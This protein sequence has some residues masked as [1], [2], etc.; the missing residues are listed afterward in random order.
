MRKACHSSARPRPRPQ[1]SAW[2]RSSV[3]GRVVNRLLAFERAHQF[4]LA[5][6]GPSAV[7]RRRLLDSSLVLTSGAKGFSKPTRW[8]DLSSLLLLGR[9]PE[10]PIQQLVESQ[11]RASASSAVFGPSFNHLHTLLA[12][13]ESGAGS[14]ILPDFVTAAA[15]R[16]Q[17]T[18]QLLRGTVS[19]TFTRS[20]GPDG[21]TMMS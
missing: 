7:R 19:V 15:S 1:R 18:I 10:I 4:D 3:V 14:A 20:P 11:V 2:L 16:Y 9:P 21:Q 17:V 13:V 8:K 12:M 5:S 6:S